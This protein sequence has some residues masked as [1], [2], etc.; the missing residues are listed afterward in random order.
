M[1][2][3][4]SNAARSA[5]ADAVVDRIDAG[6]DEGYVEI[7]SGGQPAGPDTAATGTL[8]VTIPLNDPAF[9]AAVNG[10]ATADVTPEPSAAAVATGTAGWFR[11]YDSDGVAIV[12]GL[13]GAEMTL[14][15]T[16]VVF[17]V[18]VTITSFTVTQPASS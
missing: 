1:A 3:R 17:G 15:T 11:V 8:L 10:V 18:D 13:V 6:S 12:D 16:A 14:N 5:A 7:R 2:F 4:L 9:G